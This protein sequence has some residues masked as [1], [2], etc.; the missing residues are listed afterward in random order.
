[1]RANGWCIALFVLLINEATYDISLSVT[2]VS[3]VSISRQ[4]LMKKKKLP[5]Y[6]RPHSKWETSFQLKVTYDVRILLKG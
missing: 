6:Y 4:K 1:L 3:Y 2:I 5:R